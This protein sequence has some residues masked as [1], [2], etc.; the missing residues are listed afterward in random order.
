[1]YPLKLQ[2]CTLF[3]CEIQGARV[4]DTTEFP[5]Q[6]GNLAI[7]CTSSLPFASQMLLEKLSFRKYY[8]LLNKLLQRESPIF[9]IP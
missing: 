2:A 5:D 3:P 4:G 8:R 6:H 7:S 1:M 9:Y